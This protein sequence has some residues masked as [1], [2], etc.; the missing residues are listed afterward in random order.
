MHRFILPVA[1]FVT[2]LAASFHAQDPPL[3]NTRLTVHTLLRE[4]I[5]A[6][7][8]D[9]DMERFT[10]GEKNIDE[11]LMKRPSQK[12][13]LLAWKAGATLF[14]AVLASEAKRTGEFKEKYRQAQELFT[15]AGKGTSGNSGVAAITGGSLAIFADRLPKV[16]RAAAWQQAYDAYQALYKQQS[17]VIKV[18]PVHIRGELL[19]GMAESAQRTGHMQETADA[20]DRIVT[21]LPG[22][23]YEE[24]AKQWK[25]DPASAANVKI[26]CLTCHESGRLQARLTALESK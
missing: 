4:D 23:P 7:F 9:N 11:L 1:A 20:L 17:G 8:M 13:D 22:T 26:T 3:S 18:L 15:E 24:V 21:L 10:R 2:L 25:A 14:R 6:G 5:F 16:L 19:A 12:P